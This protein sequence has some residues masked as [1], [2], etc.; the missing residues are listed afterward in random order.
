VRE[1]AVA[2]NVS[3]DGAIGPE[4]ELRGAGSE[5]ELRGVGSASS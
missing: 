1:G 2:V 3:D 4:N 5:S